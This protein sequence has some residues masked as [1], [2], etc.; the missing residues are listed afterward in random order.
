MLADG[1]R[2]RTHVM[3][4]HAL[5]NLT[6]IFAIAVILDGCA[7]HPSVA[8][9]PVGS[10]A[11]PWEPMNRRT[12]NV[13][14]KLDQI[15]LKPIAKGYQRAVPGPVRTGIDNF[16]VNLRSPWYAVNNL[17]QGKG[18]ASLV[19]AGRFLANSTFGLGGLLDVATDMG[20]E[21]HQEDFGQT[22]AVWG[23]PDGPYVVVPFFGPQTFRDALALPLDFLAD[24]LIHYDDSSVRDKLYILRIISLRERYL[25]AERLLDESFDPYIRLR[26]AY[27]QNRRYEVYDGNPPM[28]DDF[29]DDFYD[30]SED[31]LKQDES[32]PADKN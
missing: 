24:P 29:Y 13:N 2:H 4:E 23:V 5:R 20:L 15:S 12:Y 17:L 32:G 21:P 18:R 9:S 1:C 19:E 28:D 30:D 26:E 11:D 31:D 27:L 10:T 16:F 22:L 8:G 7:S 3:T 14:R 25:G 6:C